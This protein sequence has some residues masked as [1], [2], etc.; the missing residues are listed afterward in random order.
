M[1]LFGLAFVLY[2]VITVDS[3][4]D[5]ALILIII[6]IIAALQM[7]GTCINNKLSKV[8]IKAGGISYEMLLIHPIVILAFKLIPT[9][10]PYILI[11]MYIGSVVL[12]SLLFKLG[13]EKLLSNLRHR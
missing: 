4:D 13:Y 9:C 5:I 2:F 8:L 12:L 7:Q 10:C 6:V 1:L 3:Y 11:P